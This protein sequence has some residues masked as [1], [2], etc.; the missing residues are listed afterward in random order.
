MMKDKLTGFVEDLDSIC[1]AGL[2]SVLCQSFGLAKDAG[3]MLITRR[4]AS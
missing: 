1:S 4:A 3:P 2:D